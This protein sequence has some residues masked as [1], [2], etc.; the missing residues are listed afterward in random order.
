[1][2]TILR[3][4]GALIIISAAFYPKIRLAETLMFA[5]FV[6]FLNLVYTLRNHEKITGK[7]IGFILITFGAIIASGHI[8]FTGVCPFYLFL[9]MSGL[10]VYVGEKLKIIEI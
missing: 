6:I 10:A 7:R 8:L 5:V 4:L 1:M 9:C 2:K 3:I